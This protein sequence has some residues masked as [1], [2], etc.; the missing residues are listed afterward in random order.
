MLKE[1]EFKDDKNDGNYLFSDKEGKTI[2][3]PIL[4]TKLPNSLALI[5]DLKDRDLFF[6]L[7]GE[8]KIYKC[9]NVKL[10]DDLG[11]N[12]LELLSSIDDRDKKDAIKFKLKELVIRP[13]NISLTIYKSEKYR[14]MELNIIKWLIDNRKQ[15]FFWLKKP[16]NNLEIGRI[17]KV[18]I[19]KENSKH[20]I[21]NNE[22]KKEN[23][24][25]IDN[26]FGKEI[27][28]PYK[29]I[30]LISF[31]HDSVVMQRK[32]DTTF[33]SGLG[34]KILKKIKPESVIF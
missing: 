30:E 3:K 17:K 25:I 7:K 12:E 15:A 2:N 22:N 24:I 34:Y 18:N 1:I 32:S 8:L 13:K 28:L 20:K 21:V 14:E 23:S 5:K 4:K 6:K 9:L 29:T 10:A 11:E 27:E 16:V 26:F 31:E 19:H 33:F